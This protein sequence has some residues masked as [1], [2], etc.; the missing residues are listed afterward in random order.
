MSAVDASDQGRS[1]RR[2]RT[3]ARDAIEVLLIA[4][5]LY[6][7]IWNLL[8]TVRVEGESM[9]N[10][11]QNHD[12][13][14]ASKISYRLHDPERG[15]IVVLIP[16]N[17]GAPTGQEKDFIKRIIGLPGDVIQIDG[18]RNPTTILIKPGG[19]GPWQRVAEPY[20]PQPWT[21]LNFCCDDNGRATDATAQPVTIPA[22]MYFVMGDNRNYSADSRIF[23]MVPRDNILAKAFMRIW[24][25]DR[26]GS[27]GAGPTL[28]PSTLVIPFP[29]LRRRLRHS[30]GRRGAHPDGADLDGAD[31]PGED[32]RRPDAMGKTPAG[33]TPVWTR[34]ASTAAR[35]T[36]C[37]QPVQ[38]DLQLSHSTNSSGEKNSA[39]SCAPRSGESLP[40]TTFMPI[41]TARSPR[42]VPGAAAAGFVAPIML[43]TMATAPGPSHT[44]ATT[45]ADVMNRTRPSKNGFPSCSA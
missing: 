17:Q 32:A 40:W 8:Q 42:M 44:I 26:F 21:Q 30:G 25:F 4:F 12:L 28:L 3:W 10:T 16:P 20:L 35:A 41:V 6:L 23:G 18:H 43:R 14:L 19:N 7:V 15:D 2:Q 31:A 5:V 13:L 39:T 27:L 24:P 37:L 33:N 9:V 38:P 11:L 29:L 34:P 36:R 45:G 22:R 1:S